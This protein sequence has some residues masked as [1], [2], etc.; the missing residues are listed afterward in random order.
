M[1]N[2]WSHIIESHYAYLN[3]EEGLKKIDMRSNL[4]SNV[5]MNTY[6]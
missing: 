4:E 5:Y 6:L 1:Q 2:L 3:Q